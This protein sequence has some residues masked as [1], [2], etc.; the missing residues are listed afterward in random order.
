VVNT[1]QRLLAYC[2][3]LAGCGSSSSNAPPADA[4]ADAHHVVAQDSGNPFGGGD[5]GDDASDGGDGGICAQLKAQV[6][7]LGQTARACNPSSAS[8]QCGA[9][10]N[11][12]CCPVSIT[13]GDPVPVENYDQAVKAYVAQCSPDCTI[14]ICGVTPSNVCDGTGSAGICR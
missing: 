12:P 2:V 9:Q 13:P 7:E 4:G 14:V 5:S 8:P 1:M 6:A 11:G 3:L 10:T